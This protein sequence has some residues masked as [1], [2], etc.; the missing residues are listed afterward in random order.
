MKTE[1]LNIGE[2]AKRSGLATSSIRFYETRGLIRD[3]KRQANGYRSYPLQ[4]LRTL[5]II[6]CAQQAGFSLDELSLLLP[7]GEPSSDKHAE[8]IASLEH[9]VRQIEEMQ[10][11]LE[12]NRQK[13]LGVIQQV[14]D[15]PEGLTCTTRADLVMDFLRE[16]VE[17]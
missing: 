5:E 16:E 17:G 15:S 8:M 13:L 7:S 12:Q 10:L 11:R 2:L 1:T 9:K 14:K 3:V 4:A 6:K